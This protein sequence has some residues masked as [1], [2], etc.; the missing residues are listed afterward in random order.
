[1]PKDVAPITQHK[2]RLDRTVSIHSDLPLQVIL[3]H[4]VWGEE[5]SLTNTCNGLNFV[6]AAICSH[7][8]RFQSLRSIIRA[9]LF[10]C[11][12]TFGSSYYRISQTSS[13]FNSFQ[14]Q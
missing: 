1:M 8:Y 9:L 5:I 10:W 12:F 14:E 13:S 7:L 6:D 2:N 4:F 3:M 11:L